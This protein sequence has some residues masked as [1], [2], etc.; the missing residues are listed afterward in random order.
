MPAIAG[1]PL[2]GDQQRDLVAARAQLCED[3]ERL[4]AGGRAHDAVALAEASPQVARDRGEHRGLVVD[5]E[6]R[7]TALGRRSSATSARCS[8]EGVPPM[9]VHGIRRAAL[10]RC[11]GSC[12]CFCAQ[13]AYGAATR[14]L[15]AAKRKDVDEPWP[16]TFTRISRRSSPRSTSSG[17]TRRAATAATSDRRR[18][19]E[20][21]VE[22]D[23]YWDLLRRRRS[24]AD[25]GG[26]PD[27]VEL[28]ERGHGRGLPAVGRSG[29]ST[30]TLRIVYNVADGDDAT[31]REAA[32]DAAAP[33]RR[34]GRPRSTE[35][36]QP[37]L[38]ATR[39]LLVEGG[40]RASRSRRWRPARASPR[41]R[42][43]GAGATRTSWR[44]PSCS[45]W[46]SRS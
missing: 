10:G 1:H 24:A 14:G 4:G 30:Q 22:L 18:L 27:D 36:E 21:K 11:D 28:R 5:G 33:A 29:R 9:T 23:R 40:V 26:N 13:A 44:W 16:K 12:Y 45:T 15:S 8:V 7:R 34:G 31:A 42:S 2:V 32:E 19:A 17:S 6:D 25:A 39:E 38:Q 3:L 20:I 37:I 43:T 35:C 41:R 46:S